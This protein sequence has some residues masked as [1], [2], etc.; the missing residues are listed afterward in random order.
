MIRVPNNSA[1]RIQT[2]GTNGSS[3]SGGV[4]NRAT[5]TISGT[6]GWGGLIVWGAV[7]SG[8]IDNSGLIE[9]PQ[10]VVL[11]LSSTCT[12]DLIN[13]SGA[14]IQGTVAGS[15]AVNFDNVR[16]DGAVSNA[17]IIDGGTAASN[18]G[19]R[20]GT[21][22]VNT[23]TGGASNSGLIRGVTNS[24]NFLN[25]ANAFTLANTG[26]LS[27]PA[28]IG[29]NTLN[30]QGSA[31]RV[32]GATTGSAAGIVNVSGTFSSEGTFNV[33]TFNVAS[34]ATMTTNHN[35]TVGAGGLNNAG[36]M[37]VNSGSSVTVTATSG[38]QFLTSGHL[39]ANGTLAGAA[40][41]IQSTGTLAG[42]GT[43]NAATT[44]AGLHSPGNSPGVQT[45]GSDLTY[46]AGASVLW[47]LI[48]NTTGGSGNFD[49]IVLPTGN[50]TFSGSTALNLSFNGAGSAVNW[51]DP[52][53]NVD[54]TWLLHDL[55]SGVTTG[56][57]DFSVTTQDW[58][59]STSTLLSAAR[60][61]ASFSVG[62]TG[63]DV[64]IN[65][66]APVPEPATCM[67]AL[68]GLTFGGWQM[69]RRRKRA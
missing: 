22:A 11:R 27:G 32:I 69:Y 64:V 24:V 38:G 1:I 30:L 63:Q 23:I 18:T 26:T 2:T 14:T 60:S 31:A 55:S 42:D 10:G 35:V 19:F 52:F 49:Q 51:S 53:W 54:R 7:F 65:Y 20:V 21:F 47:E 16:F 43:V 25:P 48:G 40:V 15:I 62:L 9:G 66:V 37:I 67:M 8:N 46:Q 29:I 33:G 3:F 41:S 4:T 44:I 50:L 17:G 13:R 34:G 57:G 56:I 58:A 5:G 36:R 28:A 59:D 68:A 12:G 6:N 39:L 61:G 45:F